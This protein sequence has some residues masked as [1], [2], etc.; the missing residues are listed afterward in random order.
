MVYVRG[1][2]REFDAWGLSEWGTANV[3]PYFARMEAVCARALAAAEA[4]GA[5]PGLRGAEGPLQ[6][7]HGA[8]ALGTP[9]YGAFVRA[10]SEAGYGAL[11]DY[12]GP[13]C[14]ALAALAA[15]RRSA[16][17]RSAQE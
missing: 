1:H 2:P 17:T 12:N 15:S 14:V 16:L 13:R 11:G 7:A 3:L 4:D 5:T 10:G 8:N 6:V 9:L